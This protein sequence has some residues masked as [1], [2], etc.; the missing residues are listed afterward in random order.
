MELRAEELQGF[1]IKVLRHRCGM[2][3]KDLANAI[4]VSQPSISLYEGGGTLPEHRFLEIARA[5]SVDPAALSDCAEEKAV[6]T[7]TRRMFKNKNSV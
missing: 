3:Q 1:R 5:L 7:I 6:L 2:T 4:G